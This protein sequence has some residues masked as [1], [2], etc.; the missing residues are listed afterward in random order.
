MATAA[1]KQ[2][3]QVITYQWS[4]KDK[5]GKSKKGEIQAA[6]EQLVRT[7]LQK[8]GVIPT[9][10]SEKPKPL[11][12]SKGSIKQKNIVNFSRQMT[13][14]LKAG[15]SVTRALK[16]I[17]EGISKPIAMREM[18]EALHE[19]IEGGSSFSQA[20]SK[21]PVHFND[22]YISLVSAGEEAGVLD[23]TMDKIATNLEKSETVK[24]KVK[25][26]MTYPT[27]V[28][29][30]AVIVTTILL[31]KVI[32][33]FEDFFADFGA[34]LPALTVSVVAVSRALRDWG[35][36]LFAALVIAIF[37]FFW[38]KKR[39]RNFQKWINRVSTKIPIIGGILVLSANAR[40]ARTL[41]VLFE[42]GV[43]LVGGLRAT[44]PATGSVVYQEAIEKMADDVADG[45][46]LNFAMQD[47]GLFEPFTVQM[48]GIGEESGN[49][50]EMLAN[51]A[52]FYEEELDFKIDNLTTMLEPIIIGFL[53]LVV[54]TLV[55]AMY[56]PIFMLGDVVG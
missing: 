11:Y 51:V 53:A 1:V 39:N 45:Q 31:V 35:W 13:T 5:S 21:Y 47:T 37:A 22:L 41:S 15:M 24:K 7:Y 19:E 42:S 28:V 36:M 50:G 48:V 30:A 17:A 23:D 46:Q 3:K 52:N 44:A 34:K 55:I 29:I 56:M 38:F 16:L 8:Q 20:L 49:M 27:M 25:K 54:G 14:M 4:G 6:N 10:V 32:P 9:R 43:P 2:K 12:E 40:F 18:V 26:A 33:V